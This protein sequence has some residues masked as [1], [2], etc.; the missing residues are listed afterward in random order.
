MRW[1]TKGFFIQRDHWIKSLFKTVFK[2]MSEKN[3]D[4]LSSRLIELGDSLRNQPLNKYLKKN[5]V[6]IKT[7]V[8][9]I[10]RIT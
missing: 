4:Y 5:M 1:K 7:R 6:Q 10:K 3:V 9:M 8:C 2:V